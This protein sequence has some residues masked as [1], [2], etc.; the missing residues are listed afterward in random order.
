MVEPTTA[1]RLL[2]R[3]ARRLACAGVLRQSAQAACV[4]GVAYALVVVIV[5]WWLPAVTT[6]MESPWTLGALAGIAIVYGVL[7]SG[8]DAYRRAARAV[9]AHACTEDLFLARAGLAD[10]RVTP[11][12]APVLEEQAQARARAID[13]AAVAPWRLGRVAGMWAAGV[14]LSTLALL[15]APTASPSQPPPPPPANLAVKAAAKIEALR[16]REVQA[17]KSPAVDAALAELRRTLAELQATPTAQVRAE[18]RQVEHK[19]AELWQKAKAADRS[20][21]SSTSLGR[22]EQAKQAQWRQELAKGSVEGLRQELKDLAAAAAAGDKLAQA[23]AAAREMRAFAKQ[24]GADGLREAMT[25]LLR[26]LESGDAGATDQLAE[27]AGL[28]LDAMQQ[29]ASDLAALEQA[30][31]AEQLASALDQLDAGL[32]PGDLSAA[33]AE[34]EELMRGRLL[35]ELD[36]LEACEDCNG[37]G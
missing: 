21:R 26:Q 13:A 30:L 35:E 3:V 8:R 6:T 1:D 19:L 29:A 15:F 2:T 25:D 34:Y 18:L 37:G 5:R 9:D 32:P 22:G 20:A 11:A 27:R 23:A 36:D 14:L 12:L 7:R 4:V 31:R 33:L 16:K 10:G 24:A 28:E 17:E